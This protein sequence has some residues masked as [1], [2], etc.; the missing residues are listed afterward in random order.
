MTTQST[1]I[2]WDTF[3][4]GDWTFH[5]A[6]TDTGL[7]CITLPNETFD[8]LQH[9]VVK[10]VPG[11][12]LIH[13]GGKLHL[14]RQ[15]VEEY[16]NVRRSEFALPLDLKGTPFQIRVWEALLKVPYGTAQTYSDIADQIGH[17]NSVRAV[18][19]AN[20]ANPIP[21]VVPCH[22]VV[23]TNGRLTGYR[24]GV[25]MKAILLNLEGITFHS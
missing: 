2:Y 16:L 14:Y 21:L 4:Y 22:R 1:A 6:A 17:A 12:R 9:W 23:G 8:T 24:G 18:G 11:G 25:D 3:Q 7:C 13:D 5:L 20:G 19:K 10:H 15:Q